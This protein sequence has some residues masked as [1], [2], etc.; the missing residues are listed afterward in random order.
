MVDDTTSNKDND[1]PD[2][3]P[4]FGGKTFGELTEEE[5]EL[6]A[7]HMSKQM[8]VSGPLA[9]LCALSSRMSEEIEKAERGEPTDMVTPAM[10]DSI[11]EGYARMHPSVDDLYDIADRQSEKTARRTASEIKRVLADRDW[12]KEEREHP[13]KPEMPLTKWGRVKA[14]LKHRLVWGSGIVVAVWEVMR[15]FSD[16]IAIIE[17]IRFAIDFIK[18][19]LFS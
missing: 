14:F 15:G 7:E 1:I 11:R 8:K 10:M 13:F 4:D 9:D 2:D 18:S 17:A 6:L 16:V 19:W 3:F 5:Q 12:E